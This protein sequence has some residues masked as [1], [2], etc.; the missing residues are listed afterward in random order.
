MTGTAGSAKRPMIHD[1]DKMSSFFSAV[2][3][4]GHWLISRSS[5]ACAAGPAAKNGTFAPW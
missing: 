4:H 1:G 3:R 2:F 5:S